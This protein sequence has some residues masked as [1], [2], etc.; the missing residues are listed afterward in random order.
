LGEDKTPDMGNGRTCIV[1]EW[2]PHCENEIEMTWDTDSLGF[3]AFCPVCG[4][5]LMLCD[6]CQHRDDGGKRTDDCDYDSETD[7][8]RFNKKANVAAQNIDNR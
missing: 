3:K 8:C 2:C 6:E 5:R 4:E 7:T 1:T